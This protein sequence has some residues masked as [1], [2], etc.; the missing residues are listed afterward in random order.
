MIAR[1]I[2]ERAGVDEV[3][4]VTDGHV[5]FYAVGDVGESINEYGQRYNIQV[6]TE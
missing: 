1:R 2:V 4:W 6:G 5:V 3:H